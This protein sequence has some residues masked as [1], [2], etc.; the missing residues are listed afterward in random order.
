MFHQEQACSLSSQSAFRSASCRR[1]RVHVFE[2]RKENRCDRVRGAVTGFE[3]GSGLLIE[4]RGAG[5]RRESRR[6]K[7]RHRI[8]VANEKKFAVS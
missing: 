8:N 7:T 3:A 6:S 2:S 5:S 4:R 1:T